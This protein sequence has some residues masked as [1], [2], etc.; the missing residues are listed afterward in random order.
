[1][2]Y[3]SVLRWTDFPGSASGINVTIYAKETSSTMKSLFSVPYSS[4]VMFTSVL[5]YSVLFSS[6]LWYFK[7]VAGSSGDG[8]KVSDI[9]R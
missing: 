1:M 8:F 2:H 3:L 6:Y 5:F 9:I 4:L 7:K